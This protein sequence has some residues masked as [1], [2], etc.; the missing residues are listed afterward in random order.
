[1]RNNLAS[2]LRDNY[3]LDESILEYRQAIALDPNYAQA[4]NNLGV[5][6]REKLKIQEAIAAHRR[7]IA[8]Q[9]GYANAHFALGW[10]LL[11]MGNFAEGW[12][13]YEWRLRRKNAPLPERTWE[14][15]DFNG[16]TILLHAEQ[17]FGDTIQFA[18]FIPRVCASVAAKLFSC[19]RA[20]WSGS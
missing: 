9:P 11:L 1:M 18:R 8:I 4:W 15:G 5:A 20:N 19:V 16:K 10:A 14:G 12:K 17:G 7:A 2:A 6:L 13:E 3:Q